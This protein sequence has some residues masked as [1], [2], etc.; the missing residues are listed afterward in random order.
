MT[1]DIVFSPL[2]LEQKTFNV[3]DTIRV[4][5]SFMYTAGEDTSVTVQAGP[6]HYL[7]GILDR[8]G[9]SF[10][11]TEVLL[12]KVLTPTEKQFTID[13]KLSGIDAGT[14]G[15]IVEIAGTDWNATQDSVLVVAGG[16]GGFDISSIM[17]MM[18]VVM[19]MGM[20]MTMLGEGEEGEEGGLF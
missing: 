9:V 1:L 14:Y 7:L 4:T 10:G 20:I 16:A 19:M 3:G 13:F 5:A 12:P 18:M 17:G 2:S 15:L 6:Y 11:S 8:I